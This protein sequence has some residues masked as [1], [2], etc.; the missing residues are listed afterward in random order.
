VEY[1]TSAIGH[2][3]PYTMS[4]ILNISNRY[5]IPTPAAGYCTST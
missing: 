5:S 1:C 3:S 2:S 4:W